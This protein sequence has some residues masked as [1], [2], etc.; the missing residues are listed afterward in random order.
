LVLPVT[1]PR[2]TFWHS[3]RLTEIGNRDGVASPAPTDVA[4]DV[5]AG[6]RENSYW[7]HRGLRRFV[8]RSRPQIGSIAGRNGEKRSTGNGE[9]NLFHFYPQLCGFYMP[10]RYQGKM[11]ELGK[12]MPFGE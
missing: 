12:W 6:P 7:H 8:N 4:A 9:H 5:A 3:R 1:G 2:E 10:N 11:V